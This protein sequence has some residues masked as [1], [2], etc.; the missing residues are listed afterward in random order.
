MTEED[1]PCLA[2]RYWTRLEGGGVWVPVPTTSL[3]N[4]ERGCSLRPRVSLRRRRAVLQ[5][6]TLGSNV[7]QSQSPGQAVRKWNF[8]FLRS[9]EL[10]ESCR[11]LV[12]L[13]YQPELRYWPDVGVVSTGSRRRLPLRWWS[14]KM[15]G[16]SAGFKGTSASVGNLTTRADHRSRA[17]SRIDASQIE[18]AVWSRG[19]NGYR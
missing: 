1:P 17:K 5:Q 16:M 7:R 10:R 8:T 9:R 4:L 2:P 18:T 19:V 15:N 13:H 11:V 6:D 14:A 3:G 12:L